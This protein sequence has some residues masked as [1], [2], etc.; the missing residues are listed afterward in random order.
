MHIKRDP[1]FITY[2]DACL[3]VGGGFA[4]QLFWWHV[5]WPRE[6]K[7]LTL[8]H[9][10]ITRKCHTSKDL[11]SINLLEFAVEIINYAAIIVCFKEH[12]TTCSH[13]SQLPLNWTDN[14]TSNFWIRKE[15]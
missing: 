5:E 1:D 4:D 12:P 11:V 15:T 9:L 13:E 7:K 6:I 10:K 14:M 3:E 2:G 8:K